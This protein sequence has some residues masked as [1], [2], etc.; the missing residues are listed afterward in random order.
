MFKSLDYFLFFCV[1]MSEK[2]PLIKKPED[3]QDPRAS[4]IL[5]GYNLSID[6]LPELK[7]KLYERG[8]FS[9]S[10]LTV[11][12]SS[13]TKELIATTILYFE[14][15]KR[16][17]FLIPYRE[18]SYIVSSNGQKTFEY[19]FSYLLKRERSI[20]SYEKDARKFLKYAKRLERCVKHRYLGPLLWWLPIFI[21]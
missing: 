15:T 6:E 9:I 14:F 5:Q 11:E 20:E 17:S 3:F 7:Q 16:N 19:P 21:K 12:K 4:K 13:I 1:I 18:W 10:P 8:N 2:I